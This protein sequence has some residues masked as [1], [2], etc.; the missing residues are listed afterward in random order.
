MD[1]VQCSRITS[2]S[3]VGTANDQHRQR[4]RRRWLQVI[5]LY[6]SEHWTFAHIRNVTHTHSCQ[7]MYS[8]NK[9]CFLC[10]RLSS[11]DNYIHMHVSYV[12]IQRSFFF[13]ESLCK[14][15]CVYNVCGNHLSRSAQI[16]S[17]RYWI[18]EYIG[19][20]DIMFVRLWSDVRF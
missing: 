3:E 6:V 14:F 1:S 9:L 12:C 7:F 17:F 5:R 10:V 19:I 16:R 20:H 4:R 18:Y 11:F 15:C 13:L 8:L 2:W